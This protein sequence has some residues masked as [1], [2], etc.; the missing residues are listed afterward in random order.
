MQ[1]VRHHDLVAAVPRL[2]SRPVLDDLG[3]R[4]LPLPLAMPVIPIHLAWHQ[5][6]DNDPAHA[7]LRGQARTALHNAC[8]PTDDTT[9]DHTGA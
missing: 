9:V 8:N 2:I 3:L 6:Y 4:T 7:W 5:R 1:F